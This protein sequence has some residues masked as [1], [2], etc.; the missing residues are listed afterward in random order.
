[1]LIMTNYQLAAKLGEHYH[2]NLERYVKEHPGEY[3]L[4]EEYGSE[5]FY[6]D[7]SE[8]DRAIDKKYGKVYGSTFF[9]TQIPE[10]MPEKRKEK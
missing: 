8:L 5:T 9:G 3:I 2:N 10:K 4:I 1:M 6:K 7:K